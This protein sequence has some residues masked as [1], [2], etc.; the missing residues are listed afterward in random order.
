MAGGK[1]PT[2]RPSSFTQDVADLICDRLGQG[3]SLRTICS[4]ADMPDQKT[5]FRWLRDEALSSFRQQY[6]CAREVQ[7]DTIFDEILDIADTPLEG[8][9]VKIGKDGT[10]ITRE[11][12]LGHRRLQIDARKWMAA[13]LAPK[14]YGDKLEL[15]HKGDLGPITINLVRQPEAPDA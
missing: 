8:T 5:V 10:E 11:D 12:M 2:G 7:A 9:R 1:K 6:A 4:D 15:D 13:K 3:E 14:K